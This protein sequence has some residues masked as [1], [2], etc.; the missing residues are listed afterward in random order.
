MRLKAM[1]EYLAVVVAVVTLRIIN[2]EEN[3]IRLDFKTE[4]KDI[5]VDKSKQDLQL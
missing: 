4:M 5:S 2:F 3:F 1:E